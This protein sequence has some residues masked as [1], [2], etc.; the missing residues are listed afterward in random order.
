MYK[1]FRPFGKGTTLPRG[2]YWP[3]VINH[4]L[5]GMILQVGKLSPGCR[6]SLLHGKRILICESRQTLGVKEWPKKAV[7][8]ELLE[9]IGVVLLMEEMPNNHLGCFW[10]LVNHGINTSQLVYI[11]GFLNHQQYVTQFIQIV[12]FFCLWLRFTE[13][14]PRWLFFDAFLRMLNR[15]DRVL[16]QRC[17]QRNV[18]LWNQS[19]GKTR[20]VKYYLLYIVFYISC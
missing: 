4:L 18:D 8:M 11:A 1:Q 10:N 5:H 9:S 7:P 20:L 3:W 17:R 6:D 16:D 19:S 12:L 14:N 2:T 13:S 15:H